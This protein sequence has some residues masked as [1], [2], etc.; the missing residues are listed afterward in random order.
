MAFTNT[1]PNPN[2]NEY[3]QICRFKAPFSDVTGIQFKVKIP[4][5]SHLRPGTIDYINFYCGLGPFECGIST[6]LTKT[7]AG[8]WT[9]F[10]NV[11]GTIE[12]SGNTVYDKFTG[13]KDVTLKLYIVDRAVP[14]VH[15]QAD[16][17]K[18]A[19]QVNGKV[20]DVFNAPYAP[21]SNGGRVILAA[22]QIANSLP[23]TDAWRVT[24]SAAIVSNVMYKRNAVWYDM[25]NGEGTCES[26]GNS[27]NSRYTVSHSSGQNSY[28]ATLKAD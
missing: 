6:K 8:I 17:G 22:Q 5:S 14:N 19:F 26:T 13:G 1:K 2:H 28:T 12:D 16:V 3:A 11:P 9:Q 24:H 21:N 25:T 15:P 7:S 20:M 27:K 10:W 4:N 23:T 18:V